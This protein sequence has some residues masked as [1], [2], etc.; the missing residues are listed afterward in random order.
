M[1]DRVTIR[2]AARAD[3]LGF[4]RVARETHEYH[5]ALLPEIFR[6]VAVA[7]PE[8]EFDALVAGPES[9]VLLAEFAGEIAGYATLLIRHTAHTLLVPRAVGH[10]DNFGVAAASR[11]HG[12]GRRLFAACAERAKTLG[13][14]S[15]ELNCWEANQA[16]LRFYEAQGMRVS[17][18]SL[19]LDL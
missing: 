19:T 12:I 6:S 13:A 4:T 2:Q 5:V 9:Y 18:R 15:L 17:R 16:A 14:S 1:D 3:Y 11:G 10:V 7:Y 8:D